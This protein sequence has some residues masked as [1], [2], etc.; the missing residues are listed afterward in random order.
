M[1]DEAPLSILCPQVS[2]ILKISDTCVLLRKLNY[3]E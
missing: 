1:N 2:D 3:D